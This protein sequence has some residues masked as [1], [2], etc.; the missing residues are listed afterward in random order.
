[1]FVLSHS[2]FCFGDNVYNV[3]GGTP[4]GLCH[5]VALASIFM[6]DLLEQFFAS[7]PYWKGFLPY[8]GRFIDD[9]LGFW[10]GSRASFDTFVEELNQWSLANGWGMEFEPGGF[11]CKVPFL[12]LEIYQNVAMVWHTSLYFKTTDVHAYLSPSS[13]HPSSMIN[14]IP[15]GVALRIARACSEK[16]EFMRIRRLFETIFFPRRGYLSS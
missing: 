9:I 6:A 11:G 8:F 4:M 1:M 3:V 2:W 13:N 12:D 16:E 14:N 7:H 5:S 10:R 15:L